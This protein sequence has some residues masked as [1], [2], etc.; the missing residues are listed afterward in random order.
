LLK[1]VGVAVLSGLWRRR[2]K[3]NNKTKKDLKKC[4]LWALQFWALLER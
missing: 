3:T 4:Q 2:S 1:S